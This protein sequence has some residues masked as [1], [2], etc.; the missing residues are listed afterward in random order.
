MKYV[1]TCNDSLL[2]MKREEI[3]VCAEDLDEAF[4]KARTRFARKHK[5]RKSFVNI[6]AVRTVRDAS[7]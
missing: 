7:K 2:A 4:E 5:T 6:T 3:A 1:L